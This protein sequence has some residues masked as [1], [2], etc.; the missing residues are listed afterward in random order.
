MPRAGRGGDRLTRR[1]EGAKSRRAAQARVMRRT[2]YS[3]RRFAPPPLSEGGSCAANAEEQLTAA[4]SCARG[5]L[6]GSA[7]PWRGGDMPVR[8][9]RVSPFASFTCAFSMMVSTRCDISCA[10]EGSADSPS[11]CM[12][13]LAQTRYTL[14]D[15]SN[16]PTPDM[17]IT[18]F[19]R[20]G[21]R[22][23]P[24]CGC[25]SLGHSPPDGLPGA[26][27][28]RGRGCRARRRERASPT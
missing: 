19:R 4:R 10:N 14:T 15:L 3:P 25:R 5:Q 26:R 1:H 28:R 9:A 7:A 11:G 17:N 23:A 2:E 21:R 20:S 22:S 24:R 13:R 12:V 18:K 16:F 8:Y 27:P 6:R